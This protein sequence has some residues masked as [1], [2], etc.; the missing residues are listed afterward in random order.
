MNTNFKVIGLTRLAIKPES[1]APETDA[2]T[3]W[4]SELLKHK[5]KLDLHSH[6]WHQQTHSFVVLNYGLLKQ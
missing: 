4:P 2:L 1:A 6:T 3:I 5:A